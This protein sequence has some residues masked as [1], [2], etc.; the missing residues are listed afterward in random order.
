VEGSIKILVFF[1]N[2]FFIMPDID[3]EYIELPKD[4]SQAEWRDYFERQGCSFGEFTVLPTFGPYGDHDNFNQMVEDEIMNWDSIDIYNAY[5]EQVMIPQ[6]P[7]DYWEYHRVD[8]DPYS[9]VNT[10]LQG[11]GPPDFND[12][13][14]WLRDEWDKESNG[15]I[16]YFETIKIRKIFESKYKVQGY[17]VRALHHNAYYSGIGFYIPDYHVVRVDGTRDKW[18]SNLGYMYNMNMDLIGD[19][20]IP[21]VDTSASYNEQ[22]SNW[23]LWRYVKI[24]RA[25]GSSEL[26]GFFL[27]LIPF[28][29]DSEL[30]SLFETID[31]ENSQNLNKFGLFTHMMFYNTM[32]NV[33]I[34]HN[35]D[36]IR[37]V[38][39]EW[40]Y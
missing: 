27:G 24:R 18:L 10:Q 23:Y 11:H 17:P 22:K 37:K 39:N 35:W 4:W 21:G 6:V 13:P 29:F 15:G 7:D 38:L 31:S 3:I 12:Y 19:W 28:T 33:F 40:G 1:K 5:Q 14:I 9:G 36:H 20:E 30:V 25:S 2:F 8:H 34:Y 26:G 16:R 32:P